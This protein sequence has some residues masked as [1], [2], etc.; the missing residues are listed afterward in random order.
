[1][2]YLASPESLMSTLVANWLVFDDGLAGVEVMSLL[3]ELE[4]AT[5]YDVLEEKIG[6]SQMLALPI[7][8]IFCLRL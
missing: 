2:S 4:H 7:Q 5:R 1:M 3:Q 6:G 8:N